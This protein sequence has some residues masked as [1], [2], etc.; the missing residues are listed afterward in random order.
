MLDK[1]IREKRETPDPNE[2]A[3]SL[4]GEIVSITKEEVAELADRYINLVSFVKDLNARL[5]QEADQLEVCLDAVVA[6]KKFL[7]MD[8]SVFRAGISRPLGVLAF[9]LRDVTLGG[10]PKLLRRSAKI[11]KTRPKATTSSVTTQASAAASLEILFRYKMPLDQASAFVVRELHKAGISHS[12]E[13]R[14][15]ANA[16]VRRWREEMG[17]RNDQLSER[18]YRSIVDELVKALGDHASI[19]RAK[20]EVR[21]ILRGLGDSGA[22]PP[23]KT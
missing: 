11:R 5:D 16:T 23:P 20:I 22:T 13:R 8:L 3:T 12:S 17:A 4:D 19:E 14:P 10:K 7:D 2:T 15:I 21:G 6:L 18:I 1:I 9:A